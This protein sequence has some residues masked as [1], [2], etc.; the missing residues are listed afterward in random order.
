MSQ[1]NEIA[2]EGGCSKTKAR[3][4]KPAA[5]I[6]KWK[7]YSSEFRLKA[8]RLHLDEGFSRAEVSR[9][10]GV[11][12]Q[13]IKDWVKRFH[14][15]GEAASLFRSPPVPSG[16]GGERPRLPA[17]VVEKIVELKKE[18]R[19]WGVKRIA[20]VLARWFLMKAVGGGVNAG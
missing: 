9:Q 2:P 8:V 20:Q 6:G 14:R 18:N 10:L 1:E 15:Q 11:P 7:S 4:K 19:R 13:S 12:Y 17:P 5:K 16:T 3:V